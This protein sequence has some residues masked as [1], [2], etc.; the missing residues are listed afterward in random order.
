PDSASFHAALGG[1]RLAAGN[2]TGAAESFRQ[3]LSLDP[4]HQGAQRGLRQ[5]GVEQLR[6]APTREEIIAT[7][8]PLQSSVAAC[9]PDFHGVV[10]FQ[11]EIFGPEGR[12][13]NVA[14]A[15]PLGDTPE[16]ECM[17]GI[18]RG[19]TFPDFTNP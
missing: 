13:T 7:L 9:K 4:N 19:A 18:V 14:M 1:A 3:A 16:G 17:M 12:V 5:M 8:R 2:T 15:G 6:D 10:T 11:I